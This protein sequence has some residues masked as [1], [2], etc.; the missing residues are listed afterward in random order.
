MRADVASIEDRKPGVVVGAGFV[1][2]DVVIPADLDAP[3]RVWAGGTCGNV[4]AALAY[5]GWTAYPIARLG[6]D[7]PGRRV[8]H[9]LER[10][11]VR[12]DFLVREGGEGTPVIAEHIRAAGSGGTHTFS[13]RCPFCGSDLPRYRSLRIGD[14]LPVLPKLPRPDVAFFDRV[15]AGVLRVA[16]HCARE[17]ALVVFEPSAIGNP[18]LFRRLLALSHV[19]KLSRE[20]MDGAVDTGDWSSPLLVIETLGAKG[21]RY[22]TRLDWADPEQW[23][24]MPAIPVRPVCDTAGAGDWCTTGILH[25]LGAGGVESLRN[26]DRQRLKSAILLGQSLAAW[27]CTFE[28]ARGGMYCHSREELVDAVTT[29]IE[30]RRPSGRRTTETAK[31][32]PAFMCSA[33]PKRSPPLRA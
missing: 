11:G 22:R 25:G 24:T 27:N 10:W 29:L 28:G 3:V 17:G 14:T 12:Q 6:D 31:A 16:E 4:L 9:D 23:N 19:V 20:R 26:A 21:L 30:G 7:L 5:L 33:C 18:R 32:D 15:S 8:A 2:L 1:A 13:S